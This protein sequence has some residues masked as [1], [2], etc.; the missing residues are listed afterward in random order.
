MRVLG[1]GRGQIA[2]K[3]VDVLAALAAIMLRIGEPE[4]PCEIPP[5]PK[6]KVLHAAQRCRSFS[7]IM[8]ESLAN[9]SSMVTLIVHSLE[10]RP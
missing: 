7:F 3:G 2:D 8:V 10:V 6:A 1:F 9:L 4:V 5:Q